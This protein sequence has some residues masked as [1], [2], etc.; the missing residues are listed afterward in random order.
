MDERL[1]GRAIVQLIV[2]EEESEKVVQSA[3]AIDARI[4]NITGQIVKCEDVTLTLPQ[5]LHS[6]PSLSPNWEIL[7]NVPRWGNQ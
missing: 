7:G 2:K 5:P 6:G 1:T 4:I 3:R